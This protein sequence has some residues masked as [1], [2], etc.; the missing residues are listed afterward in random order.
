MTQPMLNVILN[1]P[2]DHLLF[3]P[4]A[5]NLLWF[6]VDV[7]GGNDVLLRLHQRFACRALAVYSGRNRNVM[8][9]NDKW[10]VKLPRSWDGIADNDWEGSV[11]NSPEHIG[12][13]FHVQYART[14][15]A[16]FEEI[17]VVFMER[18]EPLTGDDIRA[19]FGHEPD[20]VM[21]VDGGQVGVNPHGRLVAY[22]YG[23]R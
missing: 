5:N 10:V 20:W 16:Y 11:R 12:S 6:D 19:R 17:P 15:M 4:Y 2:K 3:D 13:E 23:L 18:V 8:V 9:L 1:P 22:D 14:R 7:G 21:S